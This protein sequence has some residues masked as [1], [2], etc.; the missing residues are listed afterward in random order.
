MKQSSTRNKRLLVARVL[1]LCLTLA[2]VSL[3][4]AQSN[5]SAAKRMAQG[6]LEPH[7]R[8]RLRSS[9]RRHDSWSESDPAHPTYGTFRRCWKFYLG[10]S[11]GSGRAA[12]CRG[13]AADHWY[14]Q[15]E[16]QLHRI[17]IGRYR[18]G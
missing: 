11:R 10:R 16:S 14:L 9:N 2:S 15:R 13:V 18:P 17:G 4:V 6:V 12:A 8:R 7:H 5:Y 3:A 1:T